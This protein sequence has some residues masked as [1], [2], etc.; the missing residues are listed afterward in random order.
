[1]FRT[2]GAGFSQESAPHVGGSREVIVSREHTNYLSALSEMPVS[3]K[4]TL[5]NQKCGEI[6][7]LSVTEMKCF[8]QKQRWQPARFKKSNYCTPS[9][10]LLI[11]FIS[12]RSLMQN[13]RGRE[14]ISP[15]LLKYKLSGF[16]LCCSPTCT[17][18][19]PGPSGEWRMQPNAF[20]QS[21][22][23]LMA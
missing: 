21:S 9:Q 18:G 16:R 15:S 12:G 4:G 11:S 7:I 13:D 10:Q 5:S 2:P 8:F 1:M 19:P 17:G 3:L 23:L 14:R 20:L 22:G 6:F